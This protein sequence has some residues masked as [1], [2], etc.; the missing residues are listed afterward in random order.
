MISDIE[1][2]FT[3]ILVSETRLNDFKLVPQLDGYSFVG[4]N[5]SNKIGGGVGIYVLGSLNYKHRDDL[6]F[7]KESA[8]AVFVELLCAASNIIIGS[9]YRAPN[10]SHE[11]FLEEM[12]A[13]ICKLNQ[14]Q[15]MAFIGGDFNI[16]FF[17]H[18]KN[19]ACDKFLD[20]LLTSGLMPTISRT[21]RLSV[22]CESLIDNILTNCDL[23]IQSGV[24]VEDG[25]SDHFPIF[26]MTEVKLDTMAH[27]ATHFVSRIITQE[28]A[29]EFSQFLEE[30]FAQF[31][32]HVD[33]N[34]AAAHFMDTIADNMNKF[35]P[36][37]R[38]L[39]KTTP[40]NPWMTNGILVSINVKNKLY[41][42]YLHE[43]TSESQQRFKRY[44][45][46]LIDAIREAKKNYYQKSLTKCK[47]DGKETWKILK[48]I[49]GKR[50][51]TSPPTAMNLN[52]TL[53]TDEAKVANI[54]NDFFIN[55][56]PSINAS[57]VSNDTD[58]LSFLTAT[59]KSI[60][61]T[62]TDIPEVSSIIEGLGKTAPG[63]DGLT[64]H[65]L[66]L[67]ASVIVRPLVHLT[68]L[69]L[70]E[71]KFPENLKNALV[72]PIYKSGDKTLP[73]NYRPIS[74]ISNI[75]KIIE[76]VL[77]KRIYDFLESEK[78]IAKTQF[79]FRKGHSTEH[80][81]IH[82]MDYVTKHLENGKHIIG[83]Y[84]DTKKR[85]TVLIIESC[86]QK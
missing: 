22:D 19:Q 60:F 3:C 49:T 46:V 4:M 41:T 72:I 64:G 58:P 29:D 40:K 75:S 14:E 54:L 57:V 39:R 66:K 43:R 28:R 13:A 79:G 38:Y 42:T 71:G 7:S 18:G 76:R 61:L 33:V 51:V 55:V 31:D 82:F 63:V 81:V 23:K 30:E 47:G 36:S 65:I 70:Q 8:E 11:E 84:L 21:T 12:E 2:P 50:K 26:N 35:F 5:R 68:N 1:I 17:D 48:E 20:I 16:N 59:E 62:P 45:N 73:Q 69:C 78:L 24:L 34:T 6:S 25:I 15:K 9:L 44:R 86:C 77:H 27:K 74:L 56:G 32:S 85:L 53:V 80:A 52:G 83:L 10:S 37:K 67:L